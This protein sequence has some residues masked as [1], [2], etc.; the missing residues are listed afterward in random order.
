MLIR[1]TKGG[2]LI[3]ALFITAICAMMAVALAVRQRLLIHEGELIIRADQAY[4]DLQGVQYWAMAQIQQFL[5]QKNAIHQQP[6]LTKFAPIKLDG[7]TIWGDIEDAQGK[8]NLNDLMNSANQP[9]FVKLATADGIP[10]DIAANIAQVITAW[11]TNAINDTQDRYYLT[12]HPPY[13][14]PH[15]PMADKSELRLVAGV[16]PEIY[17]ALSPDVIALPVQK[18]TPQSPSASSETPPEAENSAQSGVSATPINVNS[19]SAAVFLTLDPKM[20][21]AQANNL[22]ACRKQH[23][24]YFMHQ[25][26]F[27]SACGQHAQ[28]LSL[29]PITTHS[30]YYLVHA[31]AQRKDVTMQLTSLLVARQDRDNKLRVLV[32]WQSFH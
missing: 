21:I 19:A 8:F 27:I 16:T 1:L 3:S 13:R 11:V 2:A 5:A 18:T 14:A 32:E 4:L 26:D 6:L 25:Q 9:R 20:N 15:F 22:V 10:A 31:F 7:M 23:N 29:S 28:G 17:Q 24:G 12:L 30:A